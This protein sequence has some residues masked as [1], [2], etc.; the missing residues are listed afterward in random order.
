M[1]Y[2]DTR[3]H[4]DPVAAFEAGHTG[5][6]IDISIINKKHLGLRKMNQALD[7]L[8]ALKPRCK[9]E[10]LKACIRTISSDNMINQLEQE[11]LRTIADTLECP[12]PP[13]PI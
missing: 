9:P 4:T 12:I 10:L 11:L 2:A 3:P 8:A 6:E 13:L 5:L 7:N 1:A